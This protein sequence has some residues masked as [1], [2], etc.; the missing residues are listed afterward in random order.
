[1]NFLEFSLFF[2]AL[3]WM[4]YFSVHSFWVSVYFPSFQIEKN[5]F[6]TKAHFHRIFRPGK[7]LYQEFSIFFIIY[8]RS[9]NLSCLSFLRLSIFNEKIKIQ[10]FLHLSCTWYQN[11]AKIFQSSSLGK[12]S[13]LS[14]IF[15]SLLGNKYI[16]GSF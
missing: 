13:N 5:C 16:Y 7:L 9:R 15:S 11:Y 4:K 3:S 2:I 10:T 6:L 8:K 12:F 14:K 1:M